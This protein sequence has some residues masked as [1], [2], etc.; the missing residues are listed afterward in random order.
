MMSVPKEENNINS[1]LFDRCFWGNECEKPSAVQK[2]VTECGRRMDDMLSGWQ[3]GWFILKVQETYKGMWSVQ[4]V[5]PDATW[6]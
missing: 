3:K 5:V 1:L 6:K 4:I 2:A